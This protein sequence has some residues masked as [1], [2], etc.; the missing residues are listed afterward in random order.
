MSLL[1]VTAPF[2]AVS[3]AADPV[4]A[5]TITS[6]TVTEFFT[7]HTDLDLTGTNGFR[8]QTTFDSFGNLCSPCLVGDWQNLT[9]SIGGSMDGVGQ[10]DGQTYDFN[11]NV[12]GS[13]LMFEA[14]TITFPETAASTAQFTLPFVLTDTGPFASFI[15]F[16]QASGELIQV[17]LHGSGT[18]TLFTDV[19]HFPILGTTYMPVRMTFDFSAPSETPEPAPLLLVGTMLGLTWMRRRWFVRGLPARE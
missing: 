7:G 2:T 16:Q 18:A 13:A 10:F 6:G 14:G 17:M 12:G 1:F 19:G 5:A 4:A 11:L 15:Q 3:A 8:L 9:T